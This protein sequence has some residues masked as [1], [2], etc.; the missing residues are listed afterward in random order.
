MRGDRGHGH[1]GY[2]GSGRGPGGG[3]RPFV[4]HIPVDFYLCEMAFPQVKA[5]PDESPS[6]KPC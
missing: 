4:S 1:G 2:F 5:A 6:V 3:F